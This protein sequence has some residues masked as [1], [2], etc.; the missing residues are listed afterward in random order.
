MTSRSFLLS[1]QSP[2]AFASSFSFLS[3]FLPLSLSFPHFPFALFLFF[4]LFFEIFFFFSHA[5]ARSV[6]A[7]SFRILRN[8]IA[9]VVGG[10]FFH[11]APLLGTSF[12]YGFFPLSVQF[13]CFRILRFELVCKPVPNLVPRF[14]ANSYPFLV[15]SI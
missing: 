11:L 5:C 12:W 3:T 9:P 7:L 8:A 10:W 6:V 4:F 13:D 2:F 1:P 15:G 14:C